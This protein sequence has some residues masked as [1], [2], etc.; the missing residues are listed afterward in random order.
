MAHLVLFIIEQTKNIQ[1]QNRSNVIDQNYDT[2]IETDIDDQRYS[3]EIFAGALGSLSMQLNPLN[4][5]SLKSIIN[6]N[7]TNFVTQRNG[8]D[9]SRT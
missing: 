9:I 5:I 1:I 4:K 3:D 6:V 2:T 7:T 8:T